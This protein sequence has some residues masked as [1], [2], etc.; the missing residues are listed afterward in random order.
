MVFA[1]NSEL[2]EKPNHQAM[3]GNI[4]R[5]S[6]VVPNVICQW[7]IMWR[8]GNADL[9]QPLKNRS[10]VWT[11]HYN[12]RS[13]LA[14]LWLHIHLRERKGRLISNLCDKLEV[15]CIW[16]GREYTSLDWI[17][18]TILIPFRAFHLFL[19]QCLLTTIWITHL[20]SLPL[21]FTSFYRQSW[22]SRYIN[23]WTTQ[24]SLK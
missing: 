21:I 11:Q 22:R 13:H 2:C 17:L 5:Q 23:I 18:L 9:A 6:Y 14:C 1:Q 3:Q 10:R 4:N 15:A 16:R 19:A 7:W 20:F 24:V 8:T 12:G